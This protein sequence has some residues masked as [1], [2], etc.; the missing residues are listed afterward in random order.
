MSLLTHDPATYT[1]QISSL[2]DGVRD[3]FDEVTKAVEL[4]NSHL[5]FHLVFLIL[6][7]AVYSKDAT[8]KGYLSDTKDAGELLRGIDAALFKASNLPAQL[9]AVAKEDL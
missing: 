7:D 1:S 9:S 4:L 3:N 2:L 5:Y 6:L 8:I